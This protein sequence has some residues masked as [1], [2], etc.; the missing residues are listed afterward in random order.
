VRRSA[1]V[2]R[3]FLAL[4]L[5]IGLFAGWLPLAPVARAAGLTVNSTLDVINGIDGLCTLRE[6][7]I[8]VNTHTPSG[9][10]PGECPAGDGANDTI[11]LAAG[12]TYTL[13]IP[14]PDRATMETDA[15][16]GDLDITAPIAIVVAGGGTATIDANGGVT[17]DRAIEVNTLVGTVAISGVTIRNGQA[18]MSSSLGGGS[19][20]SGGAILLEGSGNLA[21]A[22]STIS[23]NTAGNGDPSMNGDPGVGGGI[24]HLG[25]GTLTVSGSTFTANSALAGV[26]ILT[27]FAGPTVVVNSTFSG[28]AGN[29]Y[30]GYIDSAAVG[31]VS[32]LSMSQN[33]TTMIVNSTIASNTIGI[34]MLLPGSS[35]RHT[36]VAGNSTANCSAPAPE[37]SGDGYNLDSGTS[38][39]FNS[40]NGSLSSTDPL[41]RPLGSYGGPTQTQTLQV[42]SP[43]RDLVPV[44]NCTDNTGSA[45]ATDQRGTARPQGS[46]CDS[47]ATEAVITP[48][49]T[50]VTPTSGST[51]GGTLI[52]IVGSSFTP[53]STVTVGGVACTGVAIT[54]TQITCTTGP[55]TAGAKDVVVTNADG[56]G[57]TLTGAFTYRAPAI[58]GVA[59]A[60]G[61]VGGGTP[62]TI[63]GTDFVT[64]ATVTVGGRPCTAITVAATT[65]TCTTPPARPAPPMSWWSTPTPPAPAA[66]PPARALSST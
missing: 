50:G 2:W 60:S 33:A 64:G 34:G 42:G 3:A 9:P 35:V 61:P 1:A 29:G 41:L 31:G 65:I 48:V 38:C 45:L 12:A 52:T 25:T 27:G 28:N 24:A 63:S 18:S 36:I 8:A 55:N 7:I 54:P 13:T 32:G 62:L 6:A 16:K 26:A 14:N 39:G 59:P 23:G 46:A 5:A 40:A 58:T 56:V 15:T 47:G 53:G 20:T 49:P 17:H 10:A 21:L 22:N 57:A 43:A 66:P 51:S 11:T 19:V 4:V 44:A 37:V 30:G